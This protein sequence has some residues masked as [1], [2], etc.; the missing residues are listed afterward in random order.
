MTKLFFNREEGLGPVYKS[1]LNLL[2]HTIYIF[3]VYKVFD[4]ELTNI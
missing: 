4:N 3:K 1:Y 2:S